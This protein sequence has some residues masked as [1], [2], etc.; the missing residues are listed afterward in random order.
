MP[1]DPQTLVTAGSMPGAAPSAL[2]AAMPGAVPGALPGALPSVLPSATLGAMP[3]T[4]PSTVPGALQSIVP[5]AMPSVIAGPLS[6]LSGN[7]PGPPPGA[8]TGTLPLAM[9]GSLPGALPG[10][11]PGALPSSIPGGAPD[12]LPG[13]LPGALASAMP[14]SMPGVFPSPL[15][16]APEVGATPS[17]IAGAMPSSA[18]SAVV[19]NMPGTVLG[20]AVP[21]ALPGAMSI[22]GLQGALPGISGAMPTTTAPG[23]EGTALA[24]VGPDV[25]GAISSGALAG[26]LPGALPGAAPGAIPGYDPNVLAAYQQQMQIAQLQGLYPNIY[27][28]YGGGSVYPQTAMLQQAQPDIMAAAVAGIPGPTDGHSG[29]RPASNNQ[30]ALM[31]GD[32]LCPR[33]NDHVFARNP[34]C[35]RCGTAKPEGAAAE[36][37]GLGVVPNTGGLHAL[38]GGGKGAHQKALPGDWHCPKCKD[39]QFAR[40]ATCRMCGNPKP[41]VPTIDLLRTANGSAEKLALPRGRSRSGQRPRPRR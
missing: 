29:I 11:V 7:P 28:M 15:A 18:P 6:A 40:N 24:L 20:A 32:W 19:G 37:A 27:Q 35:R 1:M 31:P 22:P 12:A 13:A 8:L 33:C 16:T 36:L 17:A 39:L 21:G 26:A 5:A 30:Q 34:A 4:L 25:A 23:L 3:G 38:G 9:P 10:A 14:G 2:A 41:D